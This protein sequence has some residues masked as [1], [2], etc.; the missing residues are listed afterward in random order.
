VETNPRA[1]ARLSVEKKYLASNPELNTS[2]IG[3]LR[4]V[5]S[6]K[7]A[8]E[9]V[10]SA[11]VAM[12]AAGMLSPTTDV[13][14]LAKKAFVHMDGVTDQWVEKLEVQKVAGGQ[15]PPDQAVRLAMELG[16][17]GGPKMLYTCCGPARRK[18]F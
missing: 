16:L 18:T 14:E 15:I 5:P 2:A 1:A 3:N 11:A 7:G 13:A 10:S 6:V 8:E 9:A 12:K 17:L 4:Y